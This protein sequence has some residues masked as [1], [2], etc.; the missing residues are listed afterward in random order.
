LAVWDGWNT[1]TLKDYRHGPIP[2]RGLIAKDVEISMISMEQ[3]TMTLADGCVLV[4]PCGLDLI[5]KPG[6]DQI[7][8]YL[9]IHPVNDAPHWFDTLTGFGRIDQSCGVLM[10]TT[11]GYISP[12]PSWIQVVQTIN[13]ERKDSPTVGRHYY[14]S[15][16]FSKEMT[17]TLRGFLTVSQKFRPSTD[18]VLI[19]TLPENLSSDDTPLNSDA[20]FAPVRARLLDHLMLG[21]LDADRQIT[22]VSVLTERC[23]PEVDAPEQAAVI[24]K[25][26]IHLEDFRARSQDRR[27]K[28]RAGQGIL[29][30]LSKLFARK[31]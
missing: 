10:G 7:E 2:G 11:L 25:A 24:R 22:H 9:R 21:H 16:T 31:L 8:Y 19:F 23:V 4:R 17:E 26:Q 14:V 30:A 15:F 5:G 6:R 27:H 18:H 20:P 12:A 28:K 1:Q 3:A 13:T 29:S